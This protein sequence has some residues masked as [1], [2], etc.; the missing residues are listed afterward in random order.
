MLPRLT[1]ILQNPPKRYMGYYNGP[2]EKVQ[3]QAALPSNHPEP[4]CATTRKIP[5]FFLGTVFSLLASN[6][7]LCHFFR[8]RATPFCTLPRPDHTYL[9]SA[10]AMDSPQIHSLQPTTTRIRLWSRC[11]VLCCAPSRV[12]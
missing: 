6:P 11:A 5:P 1:R 7:A 9:L 8:L 3:S 4:R 10:Y 12:E 2:V